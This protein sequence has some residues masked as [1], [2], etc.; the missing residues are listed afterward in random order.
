MKILNHTPFSHKESPLS[1]S[2]LEAAIM[3]QL[4]MFFP[5]LNESKDY[6]DLS[7]VH[8]S[9]LLIHFL[10]EGTWTTKK[11]QFLL[12]TKSSHYIQSYSHYT[13]SAAE[14]FVNVSDCKNQ[15]Q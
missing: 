13:A 4:A 6:S 9:K 3:H 8:N 2:I 11:L 15:T 5:V 14:H 7:K 12:K 10:S 1:I